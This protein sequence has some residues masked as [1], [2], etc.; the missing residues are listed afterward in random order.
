[1]PSP[2]APA[3][4][5]DRGPGGRDLERVAQQV[6]EHLLEPARLRAHD[7]PV[8]ELGRQL[9]GP[10]AASGGPRLDPS[11]HH[12][13]QLERHRRRRAAAR[14]A[15]ARAARRRD[16]TAA[17]PRRASRRRPR[18]RRRAR[19]RARLRGS[20]G[21]AGARRAASAAGARR[22]PRTPAGDDT[23]SWSRPAVRLKDSASSADLRRARRDGDARASRSPCPSRAGRTLAAR[24]VA[25]S[26]ARARRR[27]T[28]NTT[29]RMIAPTPAST[30]QLRRMRASTN[31][32]GYVTR[33]A[34]RSARSASTIGHRE[35]LQVLL[36]ACR[37]GASR[38]SPC[39]PTRP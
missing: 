4:D 27:L 1:M 21:A 15:P 8:L 26:P 32:V 10:S 13:P 12:G 38:C 18:V 28:R 3:G 20:R 6:V 17:P 37:S 36:Q 11:V 34:H 30:N 7:E 23:S 5:P 9:D 2:A 31:D 35:V 19:R 33:D 29:A 24:R 16:A 22:R 25:G 14:L 39:R